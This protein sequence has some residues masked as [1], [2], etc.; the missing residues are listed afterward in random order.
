MC[1]AVVSQKVLRLDFYGKEREREE[2]KEKEK[3]RKRERKIG[4]RIGVCG[5][6]S[7]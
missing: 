4:R 2:E 7:T 6:T 3:R 5:S 1:T